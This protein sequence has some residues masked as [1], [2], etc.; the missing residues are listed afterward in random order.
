MKKSPQSRI[1]RACVTARVFLHGAHKEVCKETIT[2]STDL[3]QDALGE[4]VCAAVNAGWKAG[5]D[6]TNFDVV[7]SFS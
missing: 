3:P 2:M 5:Y 1:K 7:I 4:V 6:P